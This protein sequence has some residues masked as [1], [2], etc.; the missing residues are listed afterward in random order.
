[1]PRGWLLQLPRLAISC[2]N[3][4]LQLW[5]Y[6]KKVL[7]MLR[8]FEKPKLRPHTRTWHCQPAHPLSRPFSSRLTNLPPSCLYHLR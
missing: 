4:S 3:G 8:T 5:D 2:H 6:E 1:M 7:L